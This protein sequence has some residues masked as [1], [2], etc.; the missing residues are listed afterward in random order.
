MHITVGGVVFLVVIAVVI[1]G[2]VFIRYMLSGRRVSVKNISNPLK[3]RPDD[4]TVECFN[5]YPDR[6]VVERMLEKSVL[7]EADIWELGTRKVVMQGY[8]NSKWTRVDLPVD[9]K[10]P[11][12]RLA[13]M[14]GCIPYRKLL[15]LKFSL[16]EKLAPYAPVAALGIGALLFIIVL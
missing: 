15:S 6:I 9:I 5:I 12:E 13:G 4:G 16:L 8:M 7:P 3:R 2:I 10:Y 1:L 14:M 11:P